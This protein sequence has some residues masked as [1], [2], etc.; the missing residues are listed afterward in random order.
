MQDE[1]LTTAQSAQRLDVT[2]ESVRS[3]ARKGKLKPAMI[4]GRMRQRLFK[5]SEVERLRRERAKND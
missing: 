2:C 5:A 1:L 4:I 3:M